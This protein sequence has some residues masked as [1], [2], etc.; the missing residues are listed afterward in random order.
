LIYIF[1]VMSGNTKVKLNSQSLLQAGFTD[2]DLDITFLYDYITKS[3]K[4]DPMVK[5][6]SEDI[7]LEG[8]RCSRICMVDP[9]TDTIHLGIAEGRP[10]PYQ[11]HEDWAG[12]NAIFAFCNENEYQY[13]IA[14]FPDVPVAKDPFPPNQHYR[15]Y[16]GYGLEHIF[17]KKGF[18][19]LDVSVGCYNEMSQSYPIYSSS[20]HPDLEVKDDEGYYF[21]PYKDDMKDVNVLGMQ[22]N[23]F[24]PMAIKMIRTADWV[25]NVLKGTYEYRSHIISY[26]YDLEDKRYR[27][28]SEDWRQMLPEFS[29]YL[30]VFD[31]VAHF[32]INEFLSLRNCN[33][34]IEPFVVEPLVIESF[35]P[36]FPYSKIGP[37]LI[38]VS[39]GVSSV[40][41]VPYSRMEIPTS[42]NANY[43]EITSLCTLYPGDY[44]EY[45]G[46]KFYFKGQILQSTEIFLRTVTRED[47]VYFRAFVRN[48]KGKFCFLEIKSLYFISFPRNQ[49]GSIIYP[50]NC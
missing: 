1:M 48:D 20:G 5:V 13:G 49:W 32:P 37:W 6:L 27:I 23:P 22:F 34:P 10:M 4:E 8:E 3:H 31:L 33:N 26:N 44:L 15:P 47:Q 18:R 29:G 25:G 7:Y 39:R 21:T 2:I 36:P 12:V 43:I 45:Q 38:N 30:E 19:L 28:Y 24:H 14:S 42:E 16:D 17:C 11:L 50:Y 40:L 46:E 9:S 35:P 41:N